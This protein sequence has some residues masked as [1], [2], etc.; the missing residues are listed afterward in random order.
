MELMEASGI[1]PMVL[2]D[3][4][5]DAGR[6][7]VYCRY[8]EKEYSFALGHSSTF[9]G[10]GEIFG[11]VYALLN[12][13]SSSEDLLSSVPSL[14]IEVF[15]NRRLTSPSEEGIVW[16]ASS[17]T[18]E[19]DIA[20]MAMLYCA[21]E[22]G[23]SHQED[24]FPHLRYLFSI[25]DQIKGYAMA[26]YDLSIEAKDIEQEVERDFVSR[27]PKNLPLALQGVESQF[28]EVRSYLMN[29]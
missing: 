6:Y 29:L 15:D 24:P 12:Y 26:G 7:G 25:R 20:D 22:F 23:L 2:Q 18:K 4:L 11:L 19:D 1:T 21:L 9:H 3:T 13:L 10:F 8:A 5:S 16:P 17:R 27:R 28:Q 14:A